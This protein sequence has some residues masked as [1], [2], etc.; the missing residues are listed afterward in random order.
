[1]DGAPAAAVQIA[2]QR[3]LDREEVRPSAADQRDRLVEPAL[4]P[5]GSLVPGCAVGEMHSPWVSR[6]VGRG[7]SDV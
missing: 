7:W 6:F 1:M 2:D 3:G 5:F 4:L